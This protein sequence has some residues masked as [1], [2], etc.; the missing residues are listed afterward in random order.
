M[1][2]FPNRYQVIVVGADG[3]MHKDSASH[4]IEVPMVRYFLEK[5][6][7]KPIKRTETVDTHVGK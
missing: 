1:T 7:A 3:L 6:A 2:L 5:K 4:H